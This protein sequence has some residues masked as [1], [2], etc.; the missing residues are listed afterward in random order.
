MIS[1]EVPVALISLVVDPDPDLHGFA[2][3]LVDDWSQ[4]GSGSCSVNLQ[5]K[6]KICTKCWMFF[7]VWRLLL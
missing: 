4:C 3:I 5:K 1:E 2:W 6:I 7:E